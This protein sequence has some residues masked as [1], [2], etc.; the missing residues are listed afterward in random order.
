MP[1]AVD[2]MRL[3]FVCVRAAKI[4]PAAPTRFA[5]HHCMVRFPSVMRQPSL[6]KH[7][8][9]ASSLSERMNARTHSPNADPYDAAASPAYPPSQFTR[10]GGEVPT[11]VSKQQHSENLL[12]R[13]SD[14]SNIWCVPLSFFSLR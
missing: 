14:L 9:P 2:N 4:P 13:E 6:F 10:R 12:G 8:Q 5:T 7:S 11:L 3:S 1:S